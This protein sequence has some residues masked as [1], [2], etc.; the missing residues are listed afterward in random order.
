[1]KLKYP[2]LLVFSNTFFYNQI[3]QGAYHG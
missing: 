1:M 3:T 2:N